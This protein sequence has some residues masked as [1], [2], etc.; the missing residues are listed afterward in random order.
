MCEEE[1]RRAR[2]RPHQKAEL[3]WGCQMLWHGAPSRGC[4]GAGDPTGHFPSHFPTSRQSHPFLLCLQPQSPREGANSCSALS[5]PP[6][7]APFGNNHAGFPPKN[8]ALELLGWQEGTVQ[9][10]RV[11]PSPCDGL[12]RICLTRSGHQIHSEIFSFLADPSWFCSLQL[13]PAPRREMKSGTGSGR[14]HWNWGQP[15]QG[16]AGSYLK[17]AREQGVISQQ[18]KSSAVELL[19]CTGPPRAIKGLSAAKE[20][21]YL[22]MNLEQRQGNKK[23]FLLSDHPLH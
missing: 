9:V 4:A 18:D 2:T 21:Q 12:S 7:A 23:R 1:L 17:A 8:A 13:F 15:G 5:P 3:I 10:P 16:F 19:V 6:A 22:E 11:T 14:C 20:K